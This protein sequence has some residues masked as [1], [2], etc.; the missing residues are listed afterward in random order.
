LFEPVDR[1]ISLLAAFFSLVGCATQIIGGILQLAPLVVLGGS[2]SLS[3][4]NADQLQAAALLF[5]KLHSQTFNISLVMFAV[6]EL[7]IGYLIIRST[8]LPRILGVLM[9]VAGCGWLTFVWPPLATSLFSYILA[10]NVGELLLPLWLLV[11]GVDVSRWQERASARQI[12]L[13]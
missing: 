13:A 3:A 12:G 7:A 10:L 11:K 1:S 5:L 8:F 9:V 6:F 4:F 2:R